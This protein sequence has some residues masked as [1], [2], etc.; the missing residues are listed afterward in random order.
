MK[1]SS[2][3]TTRNK[4]R[5]EEKPITENPRRRKFSRSTR[6][7]CTRLWVLPRSRICD[8]NAPALLE[9]LPP[10]PYERGP[11]ITEGVGL[12]EVLS[13][14]GGKGGWWREVN[15]P[16]S[17]WWGSR[18]GV[19]KLQHRIPKLQ[20]WLWWRERGRAPLPANAYS[21]FCF[22][23]VGALAWHLV[24]T[25]LV[26]AVGGGRARLLWANRRLISLFFGPNHERNV[27]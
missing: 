19:P 1:V 17:W 4:K 10:R 16:A 9:K 24:P 22:V 7:T 26:Q 11:K 2:Q 27:W 14:E 20:R 23:C 12:V 25:D 13:G 8:K 5:R 15:Q 21:Y 18:E 6:S 3:T